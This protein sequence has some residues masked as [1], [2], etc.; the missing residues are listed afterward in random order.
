MGFPLVSGS[1]NKCSMPRKCSLT[2][3][4]VPRLLSERNKE[5]CANQTGWIICFTLGFSEGGFHLTITPILLWQSFSLGVFWFNTIIL[6][7]VLKMQH[8]LK[9]WRKHQPP[10]T[11]QNVKIPTAP[12]SDQT[13][14]HSPPLH[15][16]VTTLYISWA[17][18]QRGGSV[19]ALG[20]LS[21][22]KLKCQRTKTDRQH[23]RVP[24]PLSSGHKL[25]CLT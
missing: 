18:G 13:G 14:D 12:D 22:T 25:T 24:A 4:K 19:A 21:L 9:W 7:N 8:F 5:F 15:A 3:V 23:H 1:T 6:Q 10:S 11:P 20:M 2:V 17:Q 16:C